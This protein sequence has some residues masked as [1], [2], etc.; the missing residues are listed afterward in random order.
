MQLSTWETAVNSARGT[1]GL[2]ALFA[3]RPET[4]S[5]DEVALL[6]NISRQNTYS[7]LRDGVIPGYKIGN[8]W[9]V[10]RDELKETMRLGANSPTRRTHGKDDEED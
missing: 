6:L 7:W 2:D 1:E 8:T 9:R 10:I 5:V 4:L 3:D